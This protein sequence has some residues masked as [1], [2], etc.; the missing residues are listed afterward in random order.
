MLRVVQIVR[1][2]YQIAASRFADNICLGIQSRLFAS[3]GREM[4]DA[5]TQ[6]LGTGEDSGTASPAPLAFA[7]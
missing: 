1:A 2:Y 6:H 4:E 3:C 5:V 7:G